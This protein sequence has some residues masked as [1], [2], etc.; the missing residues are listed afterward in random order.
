[1][2][3]KCWVRNSILFS[4]DKLNYI[5]LS[6]WCQNYTWQNRGHQTEG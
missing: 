5:I 4:C 1:M 2:K 3:G 6:A